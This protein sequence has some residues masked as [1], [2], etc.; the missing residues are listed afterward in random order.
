MILD[1]QNMFSN[2]QAITVTAKSTDT[3]D[4]GPNSHAKNSQGQ[5]NRLEILIYV[6]TTFTA[7][8]AGTLTIQLRS[9]PNSDMSSPVVHDVSDTL[10]LADLVAGNKLRFQPRVPINAGRYH[11][12]NYVVGTGPMTAGALTAG[13]VRDRQTNQ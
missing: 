3:I 2:A 4:M 9:S 12:L 10:A 1:A 11:D 13:V 6:N 8:G 7:A 5:E